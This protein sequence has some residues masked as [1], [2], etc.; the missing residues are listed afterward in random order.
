MK[1]LLLSPF[2]RG[3]TVTSLFLYVTRST[4]TAFGILCRWAGVRGTIPQPIVVMSVIAVIVSSRR[5]QRM[6][7]LA[8]TLLAMR[9]LGEFIHGSIHGNEFWE[10]EYDSESQNWKDKYAL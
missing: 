1:Q 7:L 5:G 8:L 2:G 10:D 4:L 9:L 3:H 6:M